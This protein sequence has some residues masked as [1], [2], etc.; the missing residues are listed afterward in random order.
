MDATLKAEIEKLVRPKIEQVIEKAKAEAKSKS[1]DFVE[2]CPDTEWIN[3]I[4]DL[5]NKLTKQLN[6]LYE[7]VESV[8]DAL[9][10]PQEIV[11]KVPVAITIAEIGIAIAESIPSTSYTPV[12]NAPITKVKVAIAVIDL[13]L[14]IAGPVI[15]SINFILNIIL[16]KLKMVL[17]LLGMLDL[18][19]G[20]F[21]QF[22]G[23]CAEENGGDGVFLSK[24]TTQEKL[25]EE[26]LKATQ[27]QSNQLSSVVTNVNGFKMDVISEANTNTFKRRRAVA[28]NS[29]GVIMLKGEWSYS[30]NDQILINDLIF[31]IKQN[32]LKA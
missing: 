22:L 4:I 31:Y 15:T 7:M 32:K 21:L 18:L 27:E 26:L 19:I 16:E 6:N 28:R 11:D 23:D 1:K 9:E 5:K 30:S 20:I 3:S 24:I 14:D 17:D 29:Q 8:A 10:I 25:N 13:I 2:T 12:V